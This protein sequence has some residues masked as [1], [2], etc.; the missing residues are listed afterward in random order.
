M[1]IDG[2]TLD[3][4]HIAPNAVEYLRARKHAAGPFEEKLQQFARDGPRVSPGGVDSRGRERC[5]PSPGIRQ[6]Y[7]LTVGG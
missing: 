3:F 7:T 1:D 6:A 2:A 5:R 4:S